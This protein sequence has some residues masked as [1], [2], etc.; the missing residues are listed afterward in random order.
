[1]EELLAGCSYKHFKLGTGW[2]CIIPRA[3]MVFKPQVG[4]MAMALSVTSGDHGE[5]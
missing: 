1:M 4:A 3:S 2:P 5:M